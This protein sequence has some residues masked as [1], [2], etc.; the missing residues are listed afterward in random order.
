[1]RSYSLFIGEVVSNRIAVDLPPSLR[2]VLETKC[3]EAWREL[4]EIPSPTDSDSPFVPY[5]ELTRTR[6]G[7]LH[8]Y[9][10]SR[11][12]YIP[13]VVTG[14]KR[15]PYARPIDLDSYNAAMSRLQAQRYNTRGRR[16]RRTTLA[17]SAADYRKFRSWWISK[18]LAEVLGAEFSEPC[19]YEKY[20]P[21]GPTESYI[22]IGEHFEEWTGH[23][24]PK[25]LWDELK[26][27]EAARLRQIAQ[28]DR[29]ESE[30]RAA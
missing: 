21:P 4:N 9:L 24:L 10:L 12:F 8:F 22:E 2:D 17:A 14:H 23:K 28:Q 13:N 26:E 1:M 16:K 27:D 19:P 7:R 3:R 18:A 11:M 29:G 5:D 15:M 30:L 25:E 6:E 20:T